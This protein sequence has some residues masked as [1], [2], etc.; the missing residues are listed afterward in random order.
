M[1]SVLRHNFSGFFL[2]N[3]ELEKFM[4]KP[5]YQH[6]LDENRLPIIDII[7]QNKASIL[8]GFGSQF[9]DDT[10]RDILVKGRD[11]VKNKHR[12]LGN[13]YIDCLFVARVK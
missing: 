6:M 2:T 10:V 12:K 5:L 11:Y 9:P 7:L 1:D 4:E 13:V 3:D 8:K